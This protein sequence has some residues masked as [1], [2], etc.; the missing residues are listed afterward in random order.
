MDLNGIHRVASLV[1]SPDQVSSA[2]WK[3]VGSADY[4]RDGS[5]DFLWYNEAT[6]RV[7]TWYMDDDL[8]RISGQY[9]TPSSKPGWAPVAT[10]D[11][12]PGW[13]SSGGSLGPGPGGTGDIVW[14][15]D[16]D[17]KLLIW[18]MNTDSH[19]VQSVPT[20]P[21]APPNA[22]DWHVVGPR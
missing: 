5:S 18:H 20:T 14:R 15:A 3:L 12:G 9:T 22:L 10:A 17:G 4:N 21:D 2:D 16:T 1:P 7:V 8:V 19:L 6:N 11:F 13:E